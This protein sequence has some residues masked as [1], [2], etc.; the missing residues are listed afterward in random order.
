MNSL[1]HL[2]DEGTILS[3]SSAGLHSVP[4]IPTAP[5]A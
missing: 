1:H 4:A 2:D 5:I 3:A